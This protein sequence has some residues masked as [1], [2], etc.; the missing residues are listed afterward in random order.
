MQ[1]VVDKPGGATGVHGFVQQ[2]SD[3]RTLLVT[4]F[5]LFRPP[6]LLDL[7]MDGSVTWSFIAE[8]SRELGSSA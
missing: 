4:T 6:P 2:C 7:D 8:R 5:F 1:A 3:L